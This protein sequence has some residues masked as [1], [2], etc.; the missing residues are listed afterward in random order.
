MV[1]S[2]ESLALGFRLLEDLLSLLRGC[3]P[4][5][6]VVGVLVAV[7]LSKARLEMRL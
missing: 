3:L 1:S 5:C 2:H 6:A 7:L 4:V